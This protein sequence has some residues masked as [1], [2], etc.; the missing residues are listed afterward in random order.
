MEALEII[1]K[2]AKIVVFCRP[3]DS[4]G[5]YIYV[6]IYIYLYGTSIYM[7]AFQN[8]EAIAEDAVVNSAMGDFLAL[9]A[10]ACKLR[11][12]L[13]GSQM[14]TDKSHLGESIAAGV[15]SLHPACITVVFFMIHYIDNSSLNYLM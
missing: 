10:S 4:G 8:P 11:K 5:V 14:P 1:V 12:A 7:V 13:H 3:A 6:Y 9:L 15:I 2:H